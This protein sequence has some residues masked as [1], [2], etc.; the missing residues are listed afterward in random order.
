VLGATQPGPADWAEVHHPRH[1]LRL[2][3]SE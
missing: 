2:V 3:G 1:L